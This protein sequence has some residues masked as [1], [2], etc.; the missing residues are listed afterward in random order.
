MIKP[1]FRKALHSPAKIMV[2]YLLGSV[3]MF[4][5][6]IF[7]P[8]LYNRGLFVFYILTCFAFS[9]CGFICGTD[10]IKMRAPYDGLSFN[11][12]KWLNTLFWASLVLAVFKYVLY[13]GDNSFSLF[14]GIKNFFSGK[15]SFLEAYNERHMLSSATGIWKLI[16]YVTVLAGPIHWIYMPLSL[17]YWKRLSIF[18][19]IGSGF[20]LFL[21]VFQYVACGATV[22]FVYFTIFMLSVLYYKFISSHY[23]SAEPTNKRTRRQRIKLIVIVLAIFIAAVMVFATIMDSRI[24]GNDKTTVRIGNQI[25]TVDSSGTLYKLLPRSVANVLVS[26]YAYLFKPY[27]ALDMALYISPNV[28]LPMCWG[29]GG[30]WFLAD[31]VKSLLGIDVIQRT[32]NMRLDEEFGYNY[33]T[34]WH[35]VFVWLANDFSFFLVPVV[36]FVLMCLFGAAWRDYL[37]NKNMYAFLLMVLFAEFV[38]FMPMN[39]QV[40]QHSDTLFAF[41]GILVIWI[42]TR[43]KYSW[44]ASEVYCEKISH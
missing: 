38:F 37:Q 25:W 27:A 40:F 2:G 24:G 26:V 43:R 34:Q 22:G 4:L 32:Y 18:K 3:F 20:I 42:F 11:V 35:T 7:R 28:D 5:F 1:V 9:Y 14:S 33:Y 29:A 21:Y 19:K 30:S 36:L 44:N 23:N 8:V 31:N 15:Y 13:T 6:S 16:N 17:Y 39:N 12:E 41:W 10:K